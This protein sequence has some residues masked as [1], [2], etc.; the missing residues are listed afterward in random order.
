ME[1]RCGKTAGWKTVLFPAQLFNPSKMWSK[2]PN[3]WNY[4]DDLCL[5]CSWALQTTDRHTVQVH[6][7]WEEADS[8]HRRSSQKNP[9]W[10]SQGIYLVSI[11]HSVVSTWS[12]VSGGWSRPQC[13]DPSLSTT[14]D[15]TESDRWTLGSPHRLVK[16]GTPWK[17]THKARTKTHNN[18]LCPL[19]VEQWSL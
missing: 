12:W 11:F 19:P 18:Q 4:T 14:F 9:W 13:S 17:H 8:H 5:W 16:W 10:P 1:M 7:C 3:F 6:H 15:E 2:I